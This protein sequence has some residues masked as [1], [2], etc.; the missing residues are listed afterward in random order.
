[1][2]AQSLNTPMVSDCDPMQAVMG[3]PL[4]PAPWPLVPVGGKAVALDCDGGRLSSDAG[5]V[6]RKAID[7]PLG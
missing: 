1:M 7:A 4:Q 6:L 5:M 2:N 3:T